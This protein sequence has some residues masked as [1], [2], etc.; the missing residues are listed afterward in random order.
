MAFDL[1]LHGTTLAAILGMAAAV[2]LIRAG[3]LF[4]ARR[5]TPTPR[6]EAFLAHLP[7]TMF[8]AL[9]V[10]TIIEGGILYI[11]AAIATLAAARLRV[12][13][14]LSMALGI[15]TLLVLRTVTLR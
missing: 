13:M 12:P 7:G 15:G 10:P 9:I 11:G 4:L 8:V 6:V 1:S 3:G 14:V 5:V 2:Y